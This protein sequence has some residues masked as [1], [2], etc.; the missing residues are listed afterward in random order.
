VSGTRRARLT[1][2]TL[3]RP[4]H[5]RVAISNRRLIACDENGVTF[6]WKDHRI[7][8]PDR[9]KVMSQNQAF[10]G[11]APL[12][13]ATVRI[14]AQMWLVHGTMRHRSRRTPLW[15]LAVRKRNLIWS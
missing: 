14:S 1:K 13:L 6:E 15:V 9:Y 2:V 4:L 12:M 11:A 7:E 8:G 10:Q 3:S 5:P